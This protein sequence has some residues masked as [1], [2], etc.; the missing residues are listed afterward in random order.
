MNFSQ[1]HERLR[2]E[3]LRRIEREALTASRL[4]RKTGMRQ[5]HLSNFLRNKRRLSLPALDRVLAALELSIADL[6]AMPA[7]AAFLPELPPKFVPLVSQ[8]AAMNNDVITAA[9]VLEY[10]PVPAS[11]LPAL[12]AGRD[13][14][15]LPRERFVAVSLTPKQAELM[16]PVLVSGSIVV[17]DRHSN[18][19]S[20]T[21]PHIHPIYGVR[22]GRQLHFCYLSLDQNF[23]VLR[24]HSIDFRVRLLAVPPNLSPSDLVIGRVCYGYISY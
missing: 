3:L 8:Q 17:L 12:T 2:L 7:D 23:L 1:L 14:G 18:S 6:L 4:A 11:A 13:Q 16:H 24:P 21:P 19:L 22:L 15:R 5:P 20:S 10:M 9:S